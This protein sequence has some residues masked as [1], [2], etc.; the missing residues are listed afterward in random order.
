[1]CESLAADEAL[2]AIEDVAAALRLPLGCFG[3]PAVYV[4]TGRKVAGVPFRGVRVIG[5]AEGYL[6]AVPRRPRS[7]TFRS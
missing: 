3:E 4:G 1:M 6:P 7:R 2:R 5:F